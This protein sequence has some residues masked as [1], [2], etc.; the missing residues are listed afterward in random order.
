MAVSG[1]LVASSSA[2]KH[3]M[4]ALLVTFAVMWPNSS[5]SFVRSREDGSPPA[6]AM[7]S[8]TAR[9]STDNTCMQVNNTKNASVTRQQS[10]SSCGYIENSKLFIKSKIH[11]YHYQPK[12][13]SFYLFNLSIYYEPFRRHYFNTAFSNKSSSTISF[14]VIFIPPPRLSSDIS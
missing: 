13:H 5:S 10:L 7:F 1:S 12:P 14:K 11:C 4:S 8:V 3:Q 9:T 2:Y 6:S